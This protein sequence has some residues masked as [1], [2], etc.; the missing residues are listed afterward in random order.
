MDLDEFEANSNLVK[1][2]LTGIDS[3][4]EQEK[5]NAENKVKQ[6]T[7]DTSQEIDN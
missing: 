1:E 6:G 3:Q 5:T 7:V 2:T 4:I